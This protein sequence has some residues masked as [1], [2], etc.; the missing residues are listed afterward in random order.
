MTQQQIATS[1]GFEFEGQPFT[2]EEFQE[3]FEERKDYM[4]R[5]GLIY[6][7]GAFPVPAIRPRPT[8]ITRWFLNVVYGG[9]R[10]YRDYLLRRIG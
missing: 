2:L 6:A 3:A 1:G 4:L 8:R 5:L 10:G 9:D 7:G